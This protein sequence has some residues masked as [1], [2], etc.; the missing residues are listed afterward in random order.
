[1]STT[2]GFGFGVLVFSI[3]KVRFIRKS[4]WGSDL[5]VRLFL[6]KKLRFGSWIRFFDSNSVNR[7]QSTLKMFYTWHLSYSLHF[8]VF[9]EKR[10]RFFDFSGSG[11]LVEKV[12]LDGSVL[13]KI[14]W[15]SMSKF[16][17]SKKNN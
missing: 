8:L 10:N 9:S 4:K 7:C 5:G 11:F 14:I 2:K 15:S 3:D 16:G 13:K 17:S 12:R 6:P 1:M